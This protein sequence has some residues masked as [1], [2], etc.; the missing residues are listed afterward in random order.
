[1]VPKL[2]V[3]VYSYNPST[4]EAET[5]GHEFEASLWLHSMTLPQPS[6]P[7]KKRQTKNWTKKKGSQSNLYGVIH[8]LPRSINVWLCICHAH[9]GLLLDSIKPWDSKLSEGQV[10]VAHAYNPSYLG[11]WDLEDCGLRPAWAN[12]SWDSISKIPWAKWTGGV[13]QAVEYLLCK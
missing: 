5:G 3:V 11:G 6:P 13:D 4:W 9:Q 2:V 1:M 7:P 12:S 8:F 10:L